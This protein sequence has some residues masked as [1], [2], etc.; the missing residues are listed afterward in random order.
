MLQLTTKELLKSSLHKQCAISLIPVPKA[1]NPSLK[2]QKQ[3]VLIWELESLNDVLSGKWGIQRSYWRNKTEI[4]SSHLRKNWNTEEK[5]KLAA[6]EQTFQLRLDFLSTRGLTLSIPAE[7]W[8][9][10]RVKAVLM[11]LA[12]AALYQDVQAKYHYCNSKTFIL[13]DVSVFQLFLCRIYYNGFILPSVTRLYSL[14]P[15][16]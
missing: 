11:L 9:L 1:E 6:Q 16:K 2:T 15:W 7:T 14:F 4:I 12:Q 5:L 3:C 8:Y 13:I 10:N